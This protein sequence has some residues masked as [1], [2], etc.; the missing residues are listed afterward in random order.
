MLNSE[1]SIIWPVGQRVL[2][3]SESQCTSSEFEMQAKNEADGFLSD[4]EILFIA[5]EFG[6]KLFYKYILVKTD[7]MHSTYASV[8]EHFQVNA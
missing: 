8:V 6:Y 7:C 2:H 3:K 5:E 4:C 1:G